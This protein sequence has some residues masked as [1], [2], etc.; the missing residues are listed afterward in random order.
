VTAIAYHGTVND[1]PSCDLAGKGPF[2]RPSWFALLEQAGQRPLL[3]IVADER[4]AA[5]MPLVERPGRLDILTNWYA[6]TWSPLATPESPASLFDDLASQLDGHALTLS[7]LA[8]DDADRLEA[9]FRRAGWHVTRDLCDT[10]HYLPVAGRSYTQY[11]AARPGP[12]RTTLKRKARKVEVRLSRQF[13]AADWAAY[14]HIYANSWKP[15]EGDPALL[16]AFAQGESEAGHY[17]FGMAMAEGEP[18]AAQFWTVEQGTAYIHKL[19]HLESAQPLS[20]GTTLTAALMEQVIDRDHVTEVD[21]GTGND[22]YK[23]DWMEATRPRFRLTCLRP[24]NPHNWPGLA[25]QV[26]RK[27]VSPRGAG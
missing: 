7:K 18:V 13:D 9:A 25:R 4:G 24:G 20:A 27:L 2:A 12:L 6:F 1:L 19:A 14:E 3:A 11:L 5:V 21:F 23:A 10:N 15:E 16:R 26:L 17:L 22:G 8:G